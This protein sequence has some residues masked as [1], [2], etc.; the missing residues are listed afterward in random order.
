MVAGYKVSPV[1]A[2]VGAMVLKV[3]SAILA[4]L[5]LGENV[6]PEFLQWHWTTEKVCGALLSLFSD[7]PERRRQLAAFARLDA[8]METATAS[9]RQRAA[10]IVLEYSGRS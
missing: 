10:A 4:N 6:I 7:T 5:V 9:P 1:E 2:L 3:P 8:I